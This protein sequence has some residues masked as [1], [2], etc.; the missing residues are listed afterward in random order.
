MAPTYELQLVL[1]SLAV[2][3]L[4]SY[5]ALH[6][7]ANVFAATGRPARILWIAA[8][9]TCMGAGIWSMHFVG[10]L[11]TRLAIPIAFDWVVTLASLG[12]A[13]AVS[14]LALYLVS[15]ARSRWKLV[16]GGAVMGL[17]ISAMHYSGMAAIEIAPGIRYDPWIFAASV[18]IAIVASWAALGLFIMLR[19]G[20][21]FRL[22]R[23]LSSVTMGFAIVGMHYTGMAAARFSVDSICTAAPQS[24]D[25]GWLGW[26]IAGLA[27]VIL[28]MALFSSLYRRGKLSLAGKISFVLGLT[29]AISVAT[30]TSLALYH[31]EYLDAQF[32]SLQ[33]H[34]LAAIQDTSNM[35]NT[36]HEIKMG[37]QRALRAEGDERRREFEAV[38]SLGD[39]LSNE[40]AAYR[41]LRKISDE[42]QLRALLTQHGKLD[43]HVAVQEEVT[44][45]LADDTAALQ[46]LLARSAAHVE[47]GRLAA[48]QSL[49][50]RELRDVFGQ[51]DEGIASL[52]A[53]HFEEALLTTQQGETVLG[54]AKWQLAIVTLCTLLLGVAGIVWLVRS[55]TRPLAALAE[56]TRAV[57]A[58]D[59]TYN[60]TLDTRDDIGDL[61]VAFNRMVNDLRV[62]RGELEAA[63][64]DAE[65]AS[66]A[67]SDFLAN[68]SHEIR[69][70]MNAI[71]GLS[72]LALKGEMNPRQ[73]DYMTKVHASGQHLL[74][75]INDILDFSKIEAGKLDLVD[76][77]FDLQHLL[78]S[79]RDLLGAEC[80]RKGLQL[81]VE[82]A[83]GVPARLSG[84][85]FRLGQV[86]LNLAGNAVKFTECGSVAVSVHAVQA[87]GAR[88][89]LEFRVRDSGIGLTQ[90]QI[91]R[92]FNSFSQA[93]TSIARRYG[94]SGLG[95]AICK[96]ICEAMG[97]EIG[98]ESVE[99][100]GSTFWFRVSLGRAQDAVEDAT[101][102][103]DLSPLRGLAVL[104][105]EDNDINQMVAA[106]IL[107]E[108]GIEVDIAGDGAAAL[109]K[110][111]TNGYDIV[112]MDMQMPV[113]DGIEATREIRKAG[114]F[115]RLPVI[116][117]TANA[118]E[119][120]HRRCIEAG[121]NDV[122]VKPVV[123][124]DLWQ[125]LLIWTGPALAARQARESGAPAR[126]PFPPGAGL[127]VTAATAA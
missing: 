17:G 3:I 19:A 31:L 81:L 34:S 41:G 78:D 62:G 69:T 13:I 20:Q 57:A 22:A 90:D 104:L 98:F 1:A 116:A 66:R 63:K 76:A 48:A 39:R 80:D 102:Q 67:K 56:G 96:R 68:M 120:D 71:I 110:L 114:R 27:S 26:T 79:T 60:I 73:R 18:V 108:A 2:A 89:A 93:D 9:A 28:A 35:R 85:S 118:T 61:S 94:G 77:E 99:G 92:L 12:I 46:R 83:P 106:E 32:D 105:V 36:R 75:V 121:M 87:E 59:F 38:M 58:G 84:D 21:G 6:I 117:M 123:P 29:L 86:L 4:A 100:E 43:A 16:L 23:A 33:S 82:R 10:M 51:V 113:M 50:D 91:G 125:T 103:M 53:L 5:V 122:V 54:T 47:E 101:A 14:A 126:K 70:P 40:V 112:L 119:S 25:Q 42:Q 30:L 49:Y 15:T 44:G 109:A 111:R 97:G 72:H 64:H 7:V 55:L 45:T 95:L 8:G 52:R 115:A 124:E 37:L 74:G 65:A 88:V 11:A 107:R 127:A 24:V